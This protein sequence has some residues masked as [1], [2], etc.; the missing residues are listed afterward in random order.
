MTQ[1]WQPIETA[2]KDGSMFLAFNEA[3][4]DM[5]VVGW[6]ADTFLDEAGGWTDVGGQNRANAI[7][8]NARYFQSWQPLPAR[9]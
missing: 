6:T 4:G 8:L 3:H 7:W 5:V 1:G 2:P 9:P